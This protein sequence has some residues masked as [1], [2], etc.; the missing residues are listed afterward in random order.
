MPLYKAGINYRNTCCLWS[1]F[2]ST[3]GYL[4]FEGLFVINRFLGALAGDFVINLLFDHSGILM[5]Q[6]PLSGIR[7]QLKRCTCDS[8][9]CSHQQAPVQTKC[10]RAFSSS[11]GRVKEYLTNIMSLAVLFFAHMLI[12]HHGAP[13]PG[14]A[15]YYYF[16]FC[17]YLCILLRIFLPFSST[18]SRIYIHVAQ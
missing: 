4:I 8:I 18:N 7:N 14:F 1:Q 2:C 5:R 15:D 12:L 13:L 3:D 16:F 11:P 17:W 10:K 6:T 9:A